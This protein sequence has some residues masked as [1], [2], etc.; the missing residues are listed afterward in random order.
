M[1]WFVL[2]LVVVGVVVLEIVALVRGIDGGALAAAIGALG[3]IAGYAVG[4]TT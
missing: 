4:K 1:K 2:A 3:S